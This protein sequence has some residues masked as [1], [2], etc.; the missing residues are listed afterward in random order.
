M[1]LY[2][3]INVRCPAAAAGVWIIIYY[4]S[5]IICDR[6]DCRRHRRGRFL[7]GGLAPSTTCQLC[8]GTSSAE[9]WWSLN[10]SLTTCYIFLE[11]RDRNYGGI[12][13]TIV[14]IPIY[15]NKHLRIIPRLHRRTLQPE[16]T[17]SGFTLIYYS[18]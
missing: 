10:L 15:I 8:S 6:S 9:H 13:I 18:V 7:T 1:Y 11:G 14:I 16:G 12:I 5:I 2:I 3:G 4:L 17:R